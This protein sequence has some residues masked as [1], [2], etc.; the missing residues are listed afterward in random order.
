[1][2]RKRLG[3]WH[4]CLS[5]EVRDTGIWCQNLRENGMNSWVAW[6]E[7]GVICWHVRSPFYLNL[8]DFT[9]GRPVS[10]F[11]RVWNHIRPTTR[12]YNMC[13]WTLSVMDSMHWKMIDISSLWPKRHTSSL[14]GTHALKRFFRHTSRISIKI[15]NS[16]PQH[17]SFTVAMSRST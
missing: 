3:E 12:P 13:R 4:P 16:P 15:I 10:I 1:M 9:Q 8:V 14:A 2:R 17:K 7:N 5:S 6:E 11:L